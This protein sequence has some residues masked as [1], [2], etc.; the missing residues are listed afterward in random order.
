MKELITLTGD[1]AILNPET[2]AKV[3]E[4][5]R[6]AKEV[7]TKEDELKKAILL[8]MES[9]GVIKLDTGA[10]VISYVA[11]TE[12]EQLDAKALREELPDIYDTY[13]KF[14]PVKSSIRIKLKG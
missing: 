14:T 2:A 11:P 7:K 8:E 5:E 6:L 1:M 13:V 4:F 12:R 3:A 10:L 9:K